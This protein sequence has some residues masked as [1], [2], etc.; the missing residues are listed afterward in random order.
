MTATASPIHEYTPK[1]A[2]ALLLQKLES[3]APLLGARVVAAINQGTTRTIEESSQATKRKTKI[4]RKYEKS[5]SYSD[6]EALHVALNVLEA[7]LVETRLFVIEA[8]R[9]FAESPMAGPGES[10]AT[11][12]GS[13]SM[14]SGTRLEVEAEPEVVQKKESKVN[15]PLLVEAE[16]QIGTLRETIDLLRVLFTFDGSGRGNTR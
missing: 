13:I 11:S 8:T 9:D 4:K 12:A 7:H 14:P 15:V 5:D 6:E 10:I 2:L 3:G 16:A 1:Q